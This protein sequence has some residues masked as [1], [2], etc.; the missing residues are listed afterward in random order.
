MYVWIGEMMMG[1]QYWW[2]DGS[3]AKTAVGKA[4]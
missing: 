2:G 1:V 3:Y 4:R